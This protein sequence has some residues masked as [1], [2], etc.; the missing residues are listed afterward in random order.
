M[1]PP[2]VFLMQ[3][4]RTSPAKNNPRESIDG[5]KFRDWLRSAGKIQRDFKKVNASGS[6]FRFFHKNSLHF[7]KIHSI[8]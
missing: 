4:C 5:K 8:I 2:H 1:Y 7:S 6:G 3:Q